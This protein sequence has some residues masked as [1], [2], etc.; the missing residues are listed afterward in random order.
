MVERRKVT[1]A[2]TLSTGNTHHMQQTINGLGIL[3]YYVLWCTGI[4]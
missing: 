3:F 2:N 4:F 1:S